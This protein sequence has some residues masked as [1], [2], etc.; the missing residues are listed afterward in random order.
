MKKIYAG[1]ICAGFIASTLFASG[2]SA[3]NGNLS[4]VPEVYISE[5]NWAG[6]SFSTADEWFE[7]ANRTSESVDIGGWTVN[8]A[9]TSGQA[10]VLPE[11][12]V[13]S[14]LSVVLIANYA[15]GHEKSTL[16]AVTHFTTSAVA[17]PNNN[18]FLELIDSSGEV[19]DRVD[20]RGTG[21]MVGSV[22]PFTSAIRGADGFTKADVS[23]NLTDNTQLGTPGIYDE[24]FLSDDSS[25]EDEG[26]IVNEVHFEDEDESHD[27]PGNA[28]MDGCPTAGNIISDDIPDDSNELA[29][30]DN[31]MPDQEVT[32]Q[33]LPEE[34]QDG[35]YVM[36]GE[37]EDILQNSTELTETASEEV[38]LHEISPCTCPQVVNSASVMPMTESLPALV[39]QSVVL[40]E[41]QQILMESASMDL[42]QLRINEFSSNPAEGKE[43]IE[44]YNFGRTRIN[45]QGAYI[46][47]ESGGKT[48]LSGELNAGGFHVIHAPKGILNNDKDV[49]RLFDATGK[50][51][52]EVFYGHGD[53]KAPKKGEVG[54]LTSNGWR[55][56]TV[57]TPGA[58]NFEEAVFSL[59]NVQQ[60]N[61][62]VAED[63]VE[64]GVDTISVAEI[65]R[66]VPIAT[67]PTL[68]HTNSTKPSNTSSA[69]G[70]T[71]GSKI[72]KATNKGVVQETFRITVI[73]GL[74]GKQIAYV[75]GY[76]LY[77]HD[78]NWP[79]L[80]AGDVVRV[81][82][83]F[84]ESKGEKRFKV[85]IGTT[86]E[87]LG[88]EG[89]AFRALQDVISKEDRQGSLVVTRGTIL[90]RDA[91]GLRI[92][93]SSGEVTVKFHSSL[94][95]KGS[96]IA[97]DFVEVRGVLRDIGGNLEIH[98]FEASHVKPLVKASDIDSVSLAESVDESS[99][100]NAEQGTTNSVSANESQETIPFAGLGLFTGS[101][102]AVGYWFKKYKM[103]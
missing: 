93:T 23:M 26:E 45:L 55:I 65:A 16:D 27:S 14:P 68:A 67:E 7:I 75:N 82:G 80:K 41:Q 101:L 90:M 84:T 44:L 18:L 78:S 73:P 58:M 57:A 99:V 91:K 47:D 96:A 72:A 81:F 64:T 15:A 13:I 36:S 4:S 60:S 29:E 95:L 39:E 33:Y 69:S 74:L 37:D 51:I 50:L 56:V 17:L 48:V 19:V 12:L 38:N 87:V 77:L 11:D 8:G 66:S 83:D 24:I 63:E 30:Q 103:N 59:E 85:K 31:N 22:N 34:T 2:A 42:S 3:E 46:L 25:V 94:G 49:I 28:G 70:S 79:S 35:N 62:T 98:P 43:W 52:D 1:I 61:S 54:V 102:G 5:V 9:A 76:Q 40:T 92:A 20:F 100:Q 10:L 71:S 89:V 97:T 86:V 32:G 6:S 53:L 21:K 88:N